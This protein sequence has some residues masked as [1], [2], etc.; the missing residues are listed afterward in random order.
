MMLKVTSTGCRDLLLT[1]EAVESKLR[2]CMPDDTVDLFLLTLITKG[3]ASFRR[4]NVMVT[5]EVVEEAAV[6]A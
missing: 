2:S 3:T 1:K 6:A 5:V 4:Y